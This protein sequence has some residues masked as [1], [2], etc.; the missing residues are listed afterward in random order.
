[1]ITR[2]KLVFTLLIIVLISFLLACRGPHKSLS[3][4]STMNSAST[5]TRTPLNATTTNTAPQ[6]KENVVVF[7][8]TE[9]V[10]TILPSPSSIVIST[11]TVEP[12][13][14]PE[15]NEMVNTC[16]TI[17]I[18][19]DLKNQTG[20]YSLSQISFLDDQT[21]MFS[22][23]ARRDLPTPEVITT[24]TTSLNL[25]EDI[26][27]SD[28]ITLKW[29][30]LNLPNGE[31]II[32]R[33]AFT[34]LLHN[35]CPGGCLLDVIG[36][37]P[38]NKWQ[39]VQVSSSLSD[40]LGFWLVGQDEAIRL[41]NFVPT[42]S[43]WQW[44]SDS[45]MLWLVHSLYEYGLQSLIVRLD[46]M[47]PVILLEE[48]QIN[49]LFDATRYVSAF[50]PMAKSILLTVSEDAGADTDELIA[51]DLTESYTQA[52]STTIIDGLKGVVWNEATQ[53]YLLVVIQEDGL[54]V[55]DVDGEILVQVPME[56]LEI[57]F[58]ALSNSDLALGLF[59]P[60]DSYALSPSGHYLV[61][62][63]GRHGINVFECQETVQR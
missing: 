29:G 47:P 57:M 8:T 4:T 35:P 2:K 1:M 36:Q 32:Q 30:Q 17:P 22:G 21:I 34:P 40:E 41:V 62:G 56:T 52:I 49:P 58:P 51:F 45:S 54:A 3:L 23:W 44:A 27:P 43:N 63:Y 39:L 5:E 53:D 24:P 48:Q 10:A 20:I 15:A 46:L 9:L 59:L 19:F 31:V 61:I 11:P 7:A 12:T 13:I 60:N 50:N 6:P 33:P 38:D 18:R 16:V 55:T 37:S 42:F 14:S 28:W 26:V 25:N